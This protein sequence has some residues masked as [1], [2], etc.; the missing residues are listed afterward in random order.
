M[1][2]KKRKKILDAAILIMTVI[3]AIAQSSAESGHNGE[4]SETDNLTYDDI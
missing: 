3:L 2:H 4:T 1:A